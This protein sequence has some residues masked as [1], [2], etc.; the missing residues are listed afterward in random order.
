MD[1]E[2]I[3]KIVGLA[4]VAV[5]GGILL[6]GKYRLDSLLTNKK[7]TDKVNSNVKDDIKNQAMLEVEEAKR[8]ELDKDKPQ[9]VSVKDLLD[10]L[11]KKDNK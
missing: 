6:N 5:V 11:N 10:W 7:T 8:A 4:G 2:F 1:V 9:N 3:L